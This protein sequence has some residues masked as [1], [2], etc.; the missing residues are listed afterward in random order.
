[1]QATDNK[2]VTTIMAHDRNC[3][4]RSNEALGTEG[5]LKRP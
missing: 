1:M 4:E 3:R 5:T 2:L